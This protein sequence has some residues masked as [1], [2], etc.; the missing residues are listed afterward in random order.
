MTAERL[1]R[2]VAID[3][4]LAWR[5]QLMTLLGRAVPDLPCTVFFSEWEIKIL[6]ATREE[7][8]GKKNKSPL[9]LG[10]AIRLVAQLGGYL[11]R[12]CDSPPG[13]E[14]LWQGMIRLNDMA[15]GYRLMNARNGS[16]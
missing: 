3:A 14:C 12:G 10:T 9:S 13:T 5:I 6:E 16:P 4:V 2:A 8:Q 7:N 11:A 1:K 15:E